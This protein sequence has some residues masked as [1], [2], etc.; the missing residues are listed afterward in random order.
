MIKD[1]TPR[2][3]QGGWFGVRVG[4]E[5]PDTSGDGG[6]RLGAVEGWKLFFRS[7]S[8]EFGAPLPV[9]VGVKHLLTVRAP[10]TPFCVGL[11]DRIALPL[12]L[13]L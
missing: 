12:E 8:F 7:T 1:T 5:R 10:T 9:G 4:L 6:G 13:C 2:G 3:W 11:L